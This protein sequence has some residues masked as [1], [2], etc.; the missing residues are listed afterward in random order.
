[1]AA[2]F[3]KHRYALLDGEAEIPRPLQRPVWNTVA[4]PS[5]RIAALHA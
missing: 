2:F 3:A 5:E 1:M 4:I